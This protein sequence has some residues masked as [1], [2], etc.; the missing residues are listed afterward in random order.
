LSNSGL[1]VADNG[2]DNKKRK[3][4]SALTKNNE[5]PGG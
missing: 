1:D 5:S 4:K 3:K 2:T